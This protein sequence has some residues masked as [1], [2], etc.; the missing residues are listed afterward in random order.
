MICFAY[1][2]KPRRI[3]IFLLMLCLFG[4]D[5]ARLSRE[6][7][8]LIDQGRY[9]EGLARLRAAAKA[10]PRDYSYQTALAEKA[11]QSLFELLTSAETDLSEGRFDQAEV[12]FRRAVT[13]APGFSRATAGLEAVQRARRHQ[14]AVKLA[15]ESDRLGQVER[16]LD[17]LHSVLAEDPNNRTARDTKQDIETRRF[18][19]VIS[20]PLLKSRYTRPISLE[21]RDA[22]I[23]MVFDAL[24]KSSGINFIF[25]KDVRPDTRITILAKDV[26]IENAVDLI[27]EPNQL[28]SKALNENTLLIYPNNPAKV[29]EYQSLVIRSFYIENADVKQTQSMVKTMLKVRDTFIDEKLNLLVIR[30]TPDVIR[31]AEQLIGVQDQPEPEVLLE[32]EVIEVLR[33]RLIDLGLAFP[34]SWQIGLRGALAGPGSATFNLRSEAGASNLLSNPRI[35]VRNREKAKVL[36]GN[37]IPVI[38]SVVTPSTTT[39]I[40]TENIQYLDVG[41]KLDVEPSVMMSGS[42]A[43]K[44]NLEVST[45]GESVTT[46]NGTTAYR[47]GTRTAATVL[48]LRDGETQTLMGLIQDDDIESARRLPGLGDLPVLGRL[49][50]STRN[51]GQKTE[52]ILNITPRIVRNVPR[53][54]FDQAALWSGTDSTFRTVRPM[55][56]VPDAP[57]KP[58]AAAVPAKPAAV[59]VAG[60]PNQ[61]TLSW[62]APQAVKVGEEFTVSLRA[63]TAAQLSG[64]AVQMRYDP[65]ALEVIAVTEGDLLGNDKASTLFTREIDSSGGRIVTSQSREA[66]TGAAGSGALVNVRFRARGEGGTRIDLASANPVTREGRAV[67]VNASGPFEIRIGEREK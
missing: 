10:D 55:L 27:L 30:D 44:M 63:S 2:S 21:F 54:S 22:G 25:D 57:D 9:E 56:N 51:D 35:R 48:Q 26:L 34:N 46:K 61:V 66:P 39:P 41:L 49:F 42:V 45:L 13:L 14:T 60:A 3:V 19:Q 8:T 15:V 36:I 28:A 23:K 52:I 5:A 38:S 64:S 47:V 20:A 59:A 67:T 24:S 43:I 32:V 58:A 16:A 33:S 40:V 37:R 1:G 7:S 12:L 65:E 53:P 11:E 50:S 17:L 4:C 18:R 31:L 62:Q 29:K 6:G